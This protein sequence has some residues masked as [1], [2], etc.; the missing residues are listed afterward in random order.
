MIDPL[1]VVG[2]IVGL[3]VLCVAVEIILI[4]GHSLSL[5][6]SGYRWWRSRREGTTVIDPPH[7]L[8]CHLLSGTLSVGT[9]LVVGAEHEWDGDTLKRLGVSGVPFPEGTILTVVRIHSDRIEVKPVTHSS[10]SAP[11]TTAA[12]SSRRK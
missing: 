12:G 5:F 10:S 4:F 6:S 7:M 9:E 11:S 3:V 1:L 8:Q 2:I